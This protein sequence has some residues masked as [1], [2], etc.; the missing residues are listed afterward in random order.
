M[1]AVVSGD[2]GTGHS[3]ALEQC[4]VAGKTGTAQWKGKD[5]RRHIEERG[6]AWFT[7]F[8]PANNPVYAFAMVYEGQ[9][10][11]QVHG[12]AQAGP[13]IH[14]VFD[15]YFKHAPEDEP[16]LVA[17]KNSKSVT[18]AVPV[19]DDDERPEGGGNQRM[20]NVPDN[21]QAPPPPRQE[22]RRSQGGGLGGF[23]RRLFGR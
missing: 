20:E 19:N 7:G 12:G 3:A 11:E 13:V 6:L 21:F 1:V 18:K 16:V 22:E 10:G 9:P 8:L 2:T 14:E 17:M 15:N 4:Q 5:E 23:F